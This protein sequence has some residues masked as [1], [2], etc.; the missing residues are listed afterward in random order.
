MGIRQGRRGATVIVSVLL[1]SLVLLVSL[2]I[3]AAAAPIATVGCPAT[4]GRPDRQFLFVNVCGPRD[5]TRN[6][7]YGYTVVLTN[8][9]HVSTGKVKLSVFHYDPI[10]RN[11]IPYRQAP[12]RA[13]FNMDEAVWTLANLQPGRS[14]RVAITLSF[15]QHGKNSLFIVRAVGQ[16]PGA[17]G[18]M[19]KDVFFR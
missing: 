18:G 7:N 13:Q 5:V 1:A 11:S 10:T 14:F 8:G 9:G 6:I 16:H 12:G 15:R 19:K 2:P 4:V 17:V 3:G